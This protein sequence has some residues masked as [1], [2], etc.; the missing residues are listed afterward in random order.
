MKTRF[1][2][3]IVL[4]LSLTPLTLKADPPEINDFVT[5]SFR[6]IQAQYQKQ[7]FILI[8]W[9]ESCAYCMKELA[10]FGKIQTQYPELNLVT[11]ATDPFLDEMT[12]NEVIERS[13]LKLQQTW[14]F[15]EPYPEV[16]YADINKQWR[17]E[18]PLTYFFSRNQDMIAH[19]GIV[20]EA[21]L[22][23]WLNG[24]RQ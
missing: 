11:V 23:E 21:E 9:S 19:R 6:D 14:V 2:F 5:G 10:M 18:L 8:F 4:L 7:P 24:Q 16:I 20:N 12:V 17:G 13:G 3:A 22:I 1:L 15:A